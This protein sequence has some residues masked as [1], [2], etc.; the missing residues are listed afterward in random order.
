MNTDTIEHAP[1]LAHKIALAPLRTEPFAYIY[2][3]NAFSEARYAE[4]IRQLPDRRFYREMNHPD[5]LQPDG[6]SARLSFDLFPENIRQLPAAQRAFWTR[7]TREITAPEVE[8]NYKA[9]F[10]KVLEEHCHKK[11]DRI[12]IRPWPMLLRD[13]A[14]YKIAIH[15]DTPRKAITTQYYLPTDASQVHLGTVLHE[16]LP[17]GGFAEISTLPFLPNT[18]YA[19]AVTRDSWHSVK[20]MNGMG[21][22]RN[23]LMVTYYYDEGTMIEGWKLLGRK[24]RAVTGRRAGEY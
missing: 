11:L 16:R 18:G 10:K 23:T 9:K 22:P 4:L 17:D 7:F 13:I 14:G 21:P 20:V 6:R 19:F 1:G 5:A 15:P 3:Q 2:R 24:F 12:K 8:A